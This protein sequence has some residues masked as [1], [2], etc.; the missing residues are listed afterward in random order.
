MFNL[1]KSCLQLIHW[2]SVTAPLDFQT[3]LPTDQSQCVLYLT[4]TLIEKRAHTAMTVELQTHHVEGEQ[5]QHIPGKFPTLSSQVLQE[6]TSNR[7]VLYLRTS[8]LTVSPKFLG[9][10]IN[11][12]IP[13]KVVVRLK[14]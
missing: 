6:P 13:Q 9:E 3:W 4:E 11:I 2:I 12:L 7:S 1:D 5:P 8:G 10:P 14:I